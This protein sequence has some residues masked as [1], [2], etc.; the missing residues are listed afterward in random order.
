MLYYNRIDISKVIHLAK[1]NKVKNAFF[2][3]EFNHRF[4]F[5]ES[6]CSGCH[7]LAMLSVNISDVT[8]NNVD[9][10]FII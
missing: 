5:Q 9:Y 4:K 6:V 1:S 7:D 10:R 8:V 2:T 3:I